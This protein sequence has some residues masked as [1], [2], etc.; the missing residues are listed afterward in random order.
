M[1]HEAR[2]PIT[3]KS[4]IVVGVF[5][6]R[7]SVNECCALYRVRA[8]GLARLL[9]RPVVESRYREWQDAIV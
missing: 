1:R 5:L 3:K 7:A 2:P 6:P 9:N 4:K 8:Y